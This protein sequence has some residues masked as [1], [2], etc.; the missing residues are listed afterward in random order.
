[1]SRR[2]PSTGV[3][4]AAFMA[5]VAILAVVIILVSRHGSSAPRGSPLVRSAPRSE[6]Q[7]ATLPPGTEAPGFTLTDQQGRPVS[8]IQYRGQVVVLSF[9][10]S[11]CAPACVLIAQQIRGALDELDHPVPVLFVSVDPEADTPANVR[12]FLAGASLTGRAT[13][14]AGPAAA[15]PRVWRAYRVR[16]PAQGR[17][18]FEGAA[19]VLLIDP[20]GDERVLYEQEQ[21][22][23]ES[24]AHDIGKLQDG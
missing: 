24:L 13:Y 23:P 17:S 9:I 20:Q 22:T 10:D 18:A 12:R 11:T 4:L 1:V 14:L 21:L 6:F 7:G 2:Q 19:P 16:T 3:A 8:L 5:L 15:L